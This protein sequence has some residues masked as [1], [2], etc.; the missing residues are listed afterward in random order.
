MATVAAPK[1]Q[2]AGGKPDVYLI[3]SWFLK[4]PARNAKLTLISRKKT[5][6]TSK[7]SYGILEASSHG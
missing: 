2:P 1:G 5:P 7:T 4:C 6:Y 3:V